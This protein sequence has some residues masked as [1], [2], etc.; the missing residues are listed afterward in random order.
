MSVQQFFSNN[1]A[2][3]MGLLF[4]LFVLNQ[5][6]MISKWTRQR[7]FIIWGIELVELIAYNCELFTADLSYFTPW[8]ILFSAIGYSLRPMIVLMLIEIVLTDEKKL[9]QKVLL[10]FPLTWSVVCAFSAFFTDVVYSYDVQNKFHR[11]PLGYSVQ[12]CV[13]LYL[14]LF[15]TLV[16]RKHILERKYDARVMALI[17]VYL[18]LAM[19]LEALFSI[20]D[21]G[22][23]AI[24]FCTV[25][26][27]SSLQISLLK[28][29]I[30]AQE[31]N[32][33]LKK[34]LQD[35][36]QAREEM[37]RSRTIAQA[38]GEEYLSVL[39]ADLDEGTICVEKIEDGYS[40]S[41]LLSAQ[42]IQL[43]YDSVIQ[44]YA[45]KFIVPEE[46]EEF[47][48][49]FKSKSLRDTLQDRG[50]IT[51]RYNCMD[52]DKNVF[53]VE[54]QIVC[55][56]GNNSH[57]VIIGLR[58]VEALVEKE[59]AQ[60]EIMATAKREAERANAAKSNFLSRMSHDI[61]TPLNGIIGLLKI[62]EDHFEDTQLVWDNQRKMKVAANHL[63]SLINDVLQ[64]SK[65]EDDKVEITH[66][67]TDLGD[68]SHQVGT[69]IH[70]RAVEAGITLEVG[71]QELPAR[72]V[73]GSPLHLR[74]IFL[75]V[76]SN[77]IKY[78]KV[79]G[80]V[81]TNLQCLNNENGIIT[82]RWIIS[83]TGIGMSKEFLKHI[84]DPFV[85]AQNDARTEYQGIGLG[86]AIVKR[87]VEKMQGSIEISS[88]EGVGSTFVITIPFEIAKV[89]KSVFSDQNLPVMNLQDIHL[90]LVEDNGLNAEIAQTLLED[91]GVKVTLAENGK[92]AVELFNENPA[93]TFDAILMD[94]MMPVM[95]GYDATKAIRA[96][97]HPDAQQI[98]IIAMTANAFKEDA[99]QCLAV[100]MNEH[101][102]KPLRIDEV[103][104]AVSKFCRS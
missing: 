47:L 17:I 5:N 37:I 81:T 57:N 40:V 23:T 43:P 61:R 31:E 28:K 22:R 49:R 33:A 13:T 48:R 39:Q 97:A 58:N 65:L 63:L 60:M 45:E 103:V 88:T 21:I 84:F 36:E 86:M 15:A 53:C 71:A 90:M 64:M 72:Y 92:R 18:S 7:F 19:G 93:G 26:F 85:Q 44:K 75:N 54:M 67:C 80:T 62:N 3:I 74:Q 24:V 12:I 52:D 59:R 9:W 32:E 51:T 35:A 87:L 82:Y 77:C 55:V 2:P 10:Y 104:N 100:G 30:H 8:R 14:L 76:Y 101:L 6:N 25:F 96:S 78:N 27:L 50:R 95:N 4:L 94:I 20:R 68:I 83:D 69:I 41:D 34:A 1:L 38:L 16:I 66:E 98:P 56:H 89:P 102:A 11:G 42:G 79:G 91:Q 46:R 70:E 73:Y 29:T 99:D